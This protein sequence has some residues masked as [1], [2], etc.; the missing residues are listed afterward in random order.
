MNTM[1]LLAQ[2]FGERMT[3]SVFDDPGLLA[4]PVAIAGYI[5]LIAGW[6]GLSQVKEFIGAIHTLIAAVKQAWPHIQPLV[7]LLIDA[8]K[9]FQPPDAPTPEPNPLVVKTAEAPAVVDPLENARQQ[10]SAAVAAD[11]K[12][13]TELWKGRY[14]ALKAEKTEKA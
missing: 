1:L 5:S 13:L 7:I 4:T 6:F 3:T 8:L 9:K 10:W 14:N 12:E 2:T 11:D